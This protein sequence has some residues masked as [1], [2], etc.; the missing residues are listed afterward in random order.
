MI[1]GL[2][3]MLGRFDA[4]RGSYREAHALNVDLGRTIRDAGMAQVGA[5]IEL[6]A[7]DAAAAEAELRRGIAVLEQAGETEFRSSCEAWLGRVLVARGRLADALVAGA[8]ALEL[9]D[10]DDAMTEIV[11]TSMLAEAHARRGDGAESDRWAARAQA[12][13]AAVDEP[14]ARA[15]ALAD[16]AVATALLGRDAEPL[17]AEADALYE[18]KG[19]VAGRD[20]LHA[21]LGTKP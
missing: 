4:A 10:A 14:I 5:A 20:L 8:R 2:H 3:A 18:A 11:A 19:S 16:L 15:D 1:G 9:A 7:G 21:R 6:L 12:R 17:F 13:V